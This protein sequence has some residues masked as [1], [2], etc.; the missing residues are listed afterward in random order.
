M[1][2]TALRTDQLV[3]VAVDFIVV[4]FV[5]FGRGVAT[6]VALLLLLLLV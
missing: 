1:V 3:V 2:Q 6:V 5:P 4:I